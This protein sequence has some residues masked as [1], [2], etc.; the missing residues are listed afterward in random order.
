MQ[1]NKR[2]WLRGGTICLVLMLVIMLLTALT[3]IRCIG[4]SQDGTAC[5]SPQ[6]IE[7]FLININGMLHY[8]AIIYVLLPSFLLGSILGLMYGKIKNKNRV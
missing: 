6:G 2:Y 8:K 4:L 5:V 1:N 7:A 3:P